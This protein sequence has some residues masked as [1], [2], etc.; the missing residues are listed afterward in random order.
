MLQYFQLVKKARTPS[1]E[2]E[3][4]RSVLY[5]VFLRFA[6]NY[7]TGSAGGYCECLVIEGCLT[8][9]ERDFERSGPL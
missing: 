1:R 6:L 7:C 2:R 3:D 4:N 9:Y 8:K 5:S